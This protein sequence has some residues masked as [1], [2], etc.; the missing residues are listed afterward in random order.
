MPYKERV[1]DNQDGSFSMQFKCGARVLDARPILYPEYQEKSWPWSDPETVPA[2]MYWRHGAFTVDDATVEETLQEI[3]DWAEKNPNDIVILGLKRFTTDKKHHKGLNGREQYRMAKEK[4]I[5]VMNQLKIPFYDDGGGCAALNGLTV[6]KAYAY[7][8]LPPREGGGVD[9]SALGQPRKMRGPNGGHVLGIINCQDSNWQDK[10]GCY[11]KK[12]NLPDD[13]GS[14]AEER[15]ELSFHQQKERQTEKKQ[16]TQP[17]RMAGFDMDTPIEDLT[18]E[19]IDTLFHIASRLNTTSGD[20]QTHSEALAVS[21][22]SSFLDKREE[23]NDRKETEKSAFFKKAWK[24]WDDI[25]DYPDYIC[26]SSKH[27]KSQPA[28]SQMWQ[29]CQAHFDPS[30]KPR[31]N[32]MFIQQVFWQQTAHTLVWTVALHQSILEDILDSKI[33]KRLGINL[34]KSAGTEDDPSFVAGSVNW[35]MVDNICT[36]GVQELKAGIVFHQ[37]RVVQAARDS[38]A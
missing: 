28:F 15:E 4:M 17:E 7:S 26:S 23:E 18:A 30:V 1:M 36:V 31:S 9:F 24:A 32:R 37:N 16:T 33:N 14:S 2:Q 38:K 8:A 25:N 10:Y 3:L 12:E 20:L 19:Q 11:L 29:Y 27:K 22:A 6:A 34:V 21:P 5:E 13:L 35:L